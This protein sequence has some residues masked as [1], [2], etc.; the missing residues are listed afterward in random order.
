M[1][2]PRAVP[3]LGRSPAPASIRPRTRPGSIGSIGSSGLI[4]T[5]GSIAPASIVACLVL[6][7]G[8]ARAG[9]QADTDGREPGAESATGT[10]PGA[11]TDVQPSETIEIHGRA[12]EGDAVHRDAGRGL[13]DPGFVTVVH[14][15]ERAGETAS[16]AEVLAEG[17]GV[18]VR[19]T[20]GLG[21][22]SSL[23]VRG[24]EPGH[25][26]ILVDGVPVS[27]LASVGFDLGRF[28]LRS[29]SEIELYRGAVP[30]SY[31]G[32][33]LGGALNL[34]TRTGPG[35]DGE[36]MNIDA[37]LGAFGARHARVRW[38]GGETGGDGGHHLS[39]TYAGAAGDF[40]YFDDRGTNLETGD[41]RVVAR[42]NNHYDQ[43]DAVARTRGRR[44][45]LDYQAGLRSGWKDQGV[46][47]SA[48]VQSS[49]TALASM[50]HIADVQ[51]SQERLAGSPAMTGHVSAYGVLEWQR[52]QD[53]AGEVGLGVQNRR[54]TS[55][56][57][58]TVARIS[59]DPAAWGV[60]GHLTTAS[61][62]ARLDHFRDRDASAGEVGG[63]D[64]GAGAEIGASTHGRRTT[65][66]ATVAHTWSATERL[67][68]YPAVRVDWL[69]TN[70][71][72]DRNRPAP[73]A[74]DRRDDLVPSPRVS[75]RLSLA[76]SVVAKGSVG[77]YMRAPTA[78][79]LF[80]DRGFTVGNP[81]LKNEVGTSAELGLV[82]APMRPLR[83]DRVRERLRLDRVYVEA[84]LFARRAR[85]AIVF[86]SSGGP[87]A[88]ALNLGDTRVHGLEASWS[89][90]ALRVVTLQGNY[91]FLHTEQRSPMISYDRQPLPQRP[92]HQLYGRLDVE[93]TG[94]TR[95]LSV[96]G[97][98]SWVTS[99]FLDA[100]GLS[101]VPGRA[102]IG[103]G[104]RLA[105]WRA[106]SIGIEVKNLTDQRVE[107]LTLEPPPRP[108]LTSV[109]QAVA[110][111]FGY[112]L[113]G[114]A[115]YLTATWRR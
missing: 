78:L 45:A 64:E 18:Q 39:V 7:L 48:S 71:L 2:Q 105:P 51:V 35:P 21:S 12:P 91:T 75:A 34:I 114:R 33:A 70:P 66:A 107:H 52:Y 85:D 42:E 99:S 69:R 5:I 29:V 15:D 27:R 113:P 20:G 76:E 74:M 110:D 65:L 8:A 26:T 97:D 41:D 25:T 63:P 16:V 59:L 50:T 23:S 103:A 72:A 83:Q 101:R 44:G 47:G 53:P 82:F 28:D 95:A 4:E 6:S 56:S 54:Y 108:D 43:I 111:V 38:L 19:S 87:A 31:G 9:A 80:G 86:V 17:V 10:D 104:A 100:A 57:A 73:G 102:L 98:A 30:A 109:P 115:F 14:V 92:R 79:E 32:A 11:A 36:T 84:A 61:V 3:A 68:V 60:F 22:F 13:S 55:A 62:E 67:T 24:A 106:L 112:P 90:R 58:G 96:W 89:M 46:P 94:I 40:R 81:A 77:R 93:G 49:R 37:G 1:H 88:T